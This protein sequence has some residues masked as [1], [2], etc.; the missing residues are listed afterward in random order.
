LKQREEEGK[1]DE[2]IEQVSRVS[3]SLSIESST[4]SLSELKLT[5]FFKIGFVFLLKLESDKTVGLVVEQEDE[6]DSEEG[7]TT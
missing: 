7:E 6:I 4:M 2:E 1:L 5:L 3:L